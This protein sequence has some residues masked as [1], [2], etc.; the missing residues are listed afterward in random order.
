MVALLPPPGL[1][2]TAS[3][4]ELCLGDE[5]LVVLSSALL[6][7]AADEAFSSLSTPVDEDDGTT[8]R[9][10]SCCKVVSLEVCDGPDLLNLASALIMSCTSGGI[11]IVLAKTASCVSFLDCGLVRLPLQFYKKTKNTR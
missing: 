2:C 9:D 10:F 11:R 6:L 4:G 1:K 5:V 8:G 3:L 7:A